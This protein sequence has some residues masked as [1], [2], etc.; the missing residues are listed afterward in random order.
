MT[1]KKRVRL[2]VIADSIHADEDVLWDLLALWLEPGGELKPR[3]AEGHFV[4]TDRRLVFA[5]PQRGILVDLDRARIKR[6]DLVKVR[7]TMA[8]L[9]I[10]TED[11]RLFTFV[12][13]KRV[14]R[15]IAEAIEKATPT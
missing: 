7:L 13:D 10:E 2:A 14:S 6:A 4:L 9:Q 11:G 1:E 15:L 3:R 8:H 12:A 5:T